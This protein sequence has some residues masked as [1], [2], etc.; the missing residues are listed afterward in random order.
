MTSDLLFSGL[1]V[2]AQVGV[3][4]GL[5]L[6]GRRV[7]RSRTCLGSAGPINVDQSGVATIPVFATF[8]GLRGAGPWLALATNSLNPR[9]AIGPRGLEYKVLGQRTVPFD[10]IRSVDVQTG[11][12]T[13]NLCFVFIDGPFTFAANLGNETDAK[14]ALGHLP[15]SITRGFNAVALERTVRR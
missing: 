13:V 6:I 14:N 4:V 9:L 15:Q 7:V 2:V 11:L 10:K 12:G 1:V 8:T 5:F 3:L